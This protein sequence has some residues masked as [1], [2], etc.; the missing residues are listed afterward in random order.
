MSPTILE[1]TIVLLLAALLG[2][3]IW[4]LKQVLAARRAQKAAEREASRA[5]PTQEVAANQTGQPVA[6]EGEGKHVSTV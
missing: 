4:T 2:A 5:T 3:Y 6:A 1:G